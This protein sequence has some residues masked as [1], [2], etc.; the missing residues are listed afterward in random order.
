MACRGVFVKSSY[1]AWLLLKFRLK[2]V[3]WGGMNATILKTLAYFDTYE[4]PLTA[5]EVWRWLYRPPVING[6]LPTLDQVTSA[7]E[8]DPWLTERVTRVEGFYC[9]RGREYLIP[10]R[11]E[12]N[13]LI[14]RQIKK[15]QRI[16]QLFRL[17]PYVQMIA[18]SS[19]LPI[20][21][22]K[23]TSDIDLFIVCRQRTIW[24]TRLLLVGIVKLLGQR[25]TPR[26]KTDKICLSY[27]V[28]ERA[29]DLQ[30]S[31]IGVDDPVMHYHIA[32]LLPIY[33]PIGT[34]DKF[35]QANVW[36]NRNLPLCATGQRTIF[37]LHDGIVIRWWRIIADHLFSLLLAEPIQ[38]QLIRWQL[39]IMPARLKALANLDTR[40]IISED[41]LKFHDQ[42]IRSQLRQRW[43]DRIRMYE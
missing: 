18:V 5:T 9:F 42:D 12:R 26:H 39:N 24:V 32:T 35:L 14:E 36:N 27:Y 28:T 21:N 6:Q 29:L 38:Q 34:Y 25:P 43:L 31:A 20:G 4:Y 17:V 40:V 23:E 22:V 7:L 41:I 2:R 1:V 8:S 3:E 13:M 33:D 37:Q 15:V 19:S 16:V 11:K 10:L 30:P